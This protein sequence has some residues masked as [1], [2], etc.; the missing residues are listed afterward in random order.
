V[1]EMKSPV[2]GK[3]HSVRGGDT[4]CQS[5]ANPTLK[6]GGK[7]LLIMPRSMRAGIARANDASTVRATGHNFGKTQPLPPVDIWEKA[8]FLSSWLV[9]K[10]DRGL[11]IAGLYRVGSDNI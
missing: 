2:W 1:T 11:T 6:S 10:I 7:M 5:A 3:P 9:E 4:T 8:A